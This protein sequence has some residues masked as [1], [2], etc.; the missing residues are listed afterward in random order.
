MTLI[1]TS[2]YKELIEGRRERFEH[3]ERSTADLNES[4]AILSVMTK[5]VDN[6]DDTQAALTKSIADLEANTDALKAE[7]DSLKNEADK[8]HSVKEDAEVEYKKAQKTQKEEEFKLADAKEK[9]DEEEIKALQKIVDEA[10]ASTAAKKALFD[11]ADAKLKSLD[12]KIEE[13]KTQTETNSKT[14]EESNKQFEDNKERNSEYGNEIPDLTNA[15]EDL[16]SKVSEIQAEYNAYVTSSSASVKSYEEQQIQRDANIPKENPNRAFYRVHEDV[17]AVNESNEVMKEVIVDELKPDG[18]A[19]E[20]ALKAWITAGQGKE[21]NPDF[22]SASAAKDFTLA[23]IWS[24]KEVSSAIKAACEKGEF[25]LR[26]AAL[27]N[28]IIYALQ[29]AGYIV[30]LVDS[31]MIEGGDINISWDNYTQS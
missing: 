14:I 26:Y 12:S 3:L 23:N 2:L 11:Q 8:Q 31:E 30:T 4:E 28:N 25:S 18:Q 20:E 19:E 29:E 9:G 21:I 5:F 13:L 22:M 17:K 1:R 10:Q 27:P 16:K 6:F 7:I 15:I 24:T